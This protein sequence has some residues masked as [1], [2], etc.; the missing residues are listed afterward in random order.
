MSERDFKEFKRVCKEYLFKLNIAH[1][2]SYGRY[3]GVARSTTKK[4]EDLIEN[5]ISILCEEAKPSEKS[6]RGAPVLSEYIDPKILTDIEAMKARYC[7]QETPEAFTP[8]M[9]T[10][11]RIYR[12]RQENHNILRVEDP[13]AKEYEKSHPYFEQIFRGQLEQMNEGP[14]LLPIDGSAP[15]ERV[16]I[17]IEQIRKHDLR[18][19]DVISCRLLKQANFFLAGEVLAVNGLVVGSFQ[20]NRFNDCTACYPSERIVFGDGKL[21]STSTAKFFRW[22]I[23]IGKGQRACIIS[24]PKAGKTGLLAELAKAIKPSVENVTVMALLIDQSPENVGQFRKIVDKENLIFTTYDDAPERQVF[25]AEFLLKRAK[26]L[27]EGGMDVLILVDSLNALARAFNETE[28]SEGGKTFAGGLESKTIHYIKK[29][30]GAARCL[31][32]GGSITILGTI[33]EGT[34][35]PADDLICAELSALDNLEIRLSDDLARRR[36]YPALDLTQTRMKEGDVLLSESEA[37]FN[38]YIRNVFLPAFGAER[39]L[40]ILSQSENY[41]Q[42]TELV[43]AEKANDF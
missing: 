6:N 20:R 8:Q 12:F 11:E 29:Y 41:A 30:F 14:M 4:K 10:A 39:L 21:A 35:N 36:I 43:K 33:S 5:I 32:E 40:Q 38:V 26:R 37:T 22:L 24:S 16:L 17:P 9:G 25:A 3:I 15:T 23:P 1:L 28:A 34:G 42:F 2:R 27:A 19:G 13:K 31:E 7:S 18:E